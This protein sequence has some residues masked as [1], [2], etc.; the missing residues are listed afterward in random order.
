MIG[1]NNTVD[2]KVR[3]LIERM[4]SGRPVSLS[5]VAPLCPYTSL[6]GPDGITAESTPSACAVVLG[7]VPED[8]SCEMRS[9]IKRDLSAGH[10][11]LLMS[12]NRVLRDH[13]KRDIAMALNRE[14]ANDQR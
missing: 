1:A 11:V 7:F 9:D 3:K 4:K 13:A 14:P 8:F 12:N 6:I 10:I 2:R 5:E